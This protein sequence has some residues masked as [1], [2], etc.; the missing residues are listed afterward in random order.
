MERLF[1][2]IALYAA[3]GA[4]ASTRQLQ[5]IP[6]PVKAELR[7]GVFV[8]AGCRVECEGFDAR[9]DRLTALAGQLI[10]PCD[11]TSS[12]NGANTVV[13]R[14]DPAA[15]IPAE[16]YRIDISARRAQFTAGD[17]A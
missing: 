11:P 16:G 1:M 4:S 9:P 10:T 2:L 7:V 3:L 5:L 6:Q 14:R 17:E 15:G 8:T 12:W 13:L